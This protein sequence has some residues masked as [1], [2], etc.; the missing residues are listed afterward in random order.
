MNSLR[1]SAFAGLPPR[2]EDESE[3]LRVLDSYLSG[4]EA[5]QP[6]DPQKLLADHPALADQLRVY[7]KVMHLA[8]RL[9][10]DSAARPTGQSSDRQIPPL[11]NAGEG[12]GG[13]A[14]LPGSSQ[15]F[16]PRFRPRSTP[17]H[18]TARGA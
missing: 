6:A 11:A 15:M 2:A 3:V 12:W 7:L 9:V 13:Q 18:P 4:L 5:G 16:D 1:S 17:S 10:E 8:G 14:S